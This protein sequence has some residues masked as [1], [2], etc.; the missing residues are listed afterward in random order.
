MAIAVDLEL[1]QDNDYI[2]MS[3]LADA[4]KPKNEIIKDLLQKLSVSS[5]AL[6]RSRERH[7]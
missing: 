2:V 6:K 3:E 4:A 7:E 5:L 1:D